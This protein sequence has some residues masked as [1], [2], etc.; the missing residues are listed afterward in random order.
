M[1]NFTLG[2]LIALTISACSPHAY[3]NV[4]QPAVIT[5]PP[6]IKRIGIINRSLASKDDKWLNIL[7]GVLSGESIGADRE[8]AEQAL[9]AVKQ[10]LERSGRFI[11]SI[12]AVNID[13]NTA[14][15]DTPMDF[16]TVHAI[17]ER[18][19]LD[20]LVSME[21]FDSNSRLTMG[22]VED[23]VKQRDGSNL[24]VISSLATVN[25]QVTTKW[26]MYD[27]STKNIVDYFVAN[28]NKQFSA[29]G[30]NPQAAQAALPY[31]RNAINQ[32]GFANGSIYGQRISPY[33][34]TIDR[35]FYKAGN[36]NLKK[37]ALFA[38]KNNWNAAIEIWKRE[39]LVNKDKNIAGKACYNMAV[40][41]EREGNLELALEY[42]KRSASEFGLGN[43]HKYIREINARISNRNKLDYQMSG[44]NN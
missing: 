9:I 41:C 7:E 38:K 15:F 10:E 14:N 28:N 6:H 2:I 30:P 22:V 26:R 25:L 4:L 12:P 36:D 23:L 3:L 21:N 42:A 40:A 44:G 27:D 18:H 20:G 29:K 19:Q 17:C 37:A 24:K 35:K 39:M 8:G 34:T 5:I 43:G 32:S 33:W 31:K 11:V 13:G 16:N 1:K